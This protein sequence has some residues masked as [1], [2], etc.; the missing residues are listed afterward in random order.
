AP[1]LVTANG[2]QELVSSVFAV[3]FGLGGIALAWAIYGSRRVPVPRV[4]QMQTALEHKLWFDELYDVVF[5]RPAVWV[6]HALYRWIERP[7]I[8]GS[9]AEVA[10][11]TQESGRL[12]G[13]VQTGL[14][15]V[16][17]LALAAGLAVL[18]VV[19]IAVK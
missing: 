14:V 12:V 2:T 4:P 16:Y 3:I 10:L 5:Y 1:P 17:A 6:A 15:R 18:L 9:A 7:V 13:R 8:L 19:F 11:G